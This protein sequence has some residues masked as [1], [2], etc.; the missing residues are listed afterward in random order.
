MNARGIAALLRPVLRS[1]AS[2]NARVVGGGMGSVGCSNVMFT[3]FRYLPTSNRPHMLF[4]LPT[5]MLPPHVTTPM[6]QRAFVSSYLQ[7]LRLQR[8]SQ[9]DAQQS[10]KDAASASS[11]QGV[12]WWSKLTGSAGEGKAAA[13]GDA[14]LGA[15]EDRPLYVA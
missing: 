4:H 10:N 12:N 14:A 5:P 15:R 7:A 3:A 11:N 2:G 8:M 13:D 9:R 1:L 6:L